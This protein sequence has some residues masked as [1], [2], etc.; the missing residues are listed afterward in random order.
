MITYLIGF[1]HALDFAS[2]FKKAH[3]ALARRLCP[4]SRMMYEFMRS[5]ADNKAS[6]SGLAVNICEKVPPLR[7]LCW[8]PDLGLPVSLRRGT[9]FSVELGVHGGSFYSLT[10]VRLSSA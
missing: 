1:R 5:G 2:I 3:G 4:I 6:V 10:V 7:E 9:S 8:D